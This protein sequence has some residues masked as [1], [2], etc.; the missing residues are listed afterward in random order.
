MKKRTRKEVRT[1]SK[2]FKKEKVQMFEE[3]K[4]TVLELSKLYNVSR[5]AIYTWIKLYGRLPSTERYV[6]E[7]KSEGAKNI[8]LLRRISQLEKIIGQQQVELLYK[9]TVI[10]FGSNILGEDLKKKHDSK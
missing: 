8:E 1:F 10:E 5:K 3:G 9:D 6:V 2:E 4:V 7:K